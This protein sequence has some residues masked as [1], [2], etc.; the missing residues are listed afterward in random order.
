MFTIQN[1]LMSVTTCNVTSHCKF[2]D[3]NSLSSSTYLCVP[4]HLLVLHNPY[5][6]NSTNHYA[7]FSILLSLPPCY[8]QTLSRSAQS[9]PCHL[10]NT[11]PALHNVL[12]IIFRSSARTVLHVTFL[13]PNGLRWLLF[14]AKFVQP[15][16]RWLWISG[17]SCFSTWT[18]ILFAEDENVH[19]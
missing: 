1:W 11:R 18:F 10:P 13:Q 2:P 17:V 12:P 19:K 9:T 3:H 4:C 6:I 5:L 14:F 7:V 8:A 16:T 15:C